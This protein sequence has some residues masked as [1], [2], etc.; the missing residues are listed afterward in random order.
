[1]HSDMYSLWKMLLVEFVGTFTLVFVGASAV[2]LTIAQGGSLVG[3]ALAFGLAL[4]TLMYAWG[5]ISGA[6]FNP[7]TSFGYA[8]AGRMN[9]L[10]MLGYWV[11]QLVGGI[12]AGALVAYFFGTASG[13]GASI[14]S[15]TNTEPWKAV[16]LEAFLTFFLVITILMV[17]H[18][19]LFAT[20]SGFA[21]GLVLSFD[22]FA[23]FPLTGASMNPAR[24]LGPAI[25]SNNLGT[26][27][28]YIVGPLI[29]ALFAGWIYRLF[30]HDWT[31]CDKLDACGK[32]IV[33][34]C[35]NKLKECSRVLV[36]GCG[37][38]LKD[39]NGVKT[40]RYIKAERRAGFKQETPLDAIGSMMS[41]M[42]YD[43]RYLVEE[44][45]KRTPAN[46][47]AGVGAGV[48]VGGLGVGVGAGIG[49]APMY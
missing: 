48:N 30:M 46:N 33:D 1:M 45:H 3:S 7:A 39:C 47:I 11:A 27:W 40:E 24:S 32:P 34:A 17:T 36:D 18:N 8:V 19:P 15:L 5:N 4:A 38:P 37:R 28:I 10:L 13:A 12:A 35:G 49:A 14:G 41:S 9:W 16:L 43:P 21:I 26:Y 42:G 6:H 22:M 44:M 25:F 20:A 2:A 23:G 31:C 29:G